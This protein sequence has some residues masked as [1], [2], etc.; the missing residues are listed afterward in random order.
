MQERP[1]EA[2]ARRVDVQRDVE[3]LLLLQAHEQRI[4]P[5]DVVG[6]A[7]E[8]RA[9]DP[10]DADRVL[11]DQRLDVLGA[12]G[13]A[14]LRH[15]DR[16]RLDVEVAAELVPDHVHVA[17]VH[18]VRAAR[19]LSVGLAAL[20]PAPLGGQ[21]GEHDRLRRALRPGAAHVAGN[22]EEVAEHPDAALLDLRGPGVLGVVDEVAVG[23]LGD[24]PLRL[25]LHPGGHEGGEVPGGVAVDGHLLVDQVIGVLGRHAV[26]REAHVGRPLDEE[27]AGV[28]GWKILVGWAHARQAIPLYR[29]RRRF[30]IAPAPP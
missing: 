30:A 24:D 1:D 7:R 12:D 21:T 27:A 26:L 10:H 15:R 5:A 2:A 4:D 3:A 11:V 22:V 14:V 29:R 19:V 6:L 28:A 18:E 16:L 20:A 9:E 13:E 8:G 23:V 25:G 17:A